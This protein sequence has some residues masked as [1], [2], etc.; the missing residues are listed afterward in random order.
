MSQDQQGSS[1]NKIHIDED[2]KTKVESERAAE[3][4]GQNQPVESEGEAPEQIDASQ[5][6]PASFPLLVSMFSTQAMVALGLIPNPMTNKPDL[7]PALA[8]HYIDLLAV[9]EE[10]SKGNLEH[11]EEQ[12]I[13]QTVHELRMIYVQQTGQ[14]A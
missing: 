5:L 6:P 12:M 9:L 2:W 7:Q 1:D 13:T 11:E 4:A 10:K 8:R 14:N 3:A